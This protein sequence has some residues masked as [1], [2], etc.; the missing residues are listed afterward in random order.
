M[1]NL[2][3]TENY[4]K[5]VFT[6]KI[7]LRYRRGALQSCDIL[8]FAY[9]QVSEYKYDDIIHTGPFLQASQRRSCSSSVSHVPDEGYFIPV[10]CV[11]RGS[12]SAL[13]SCGKSLTSRARHCTALRALPTAEDTGTSLHEPNC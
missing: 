13:P 9:P 7:R 5:D 2:V 10:R 1:L 8:M 12:K 3:D 4:F 6:G 11:R